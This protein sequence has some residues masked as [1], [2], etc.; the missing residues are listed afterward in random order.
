MRC[1]GQQT[2]RVQN[3]NSDSTEE[4]TGGGPLDVGDVY[5]IFTQML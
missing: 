1:G 4:K 5:I 3:Y 2:A